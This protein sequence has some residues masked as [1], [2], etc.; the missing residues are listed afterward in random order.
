[1]S[2]LQRIAAM[3]RPTVE[4]YDDPAFGPLSRRSGGDWYGE[5]PFQHPPTGSSS[6]SILI[7]AGEGH[8]SDEQRAFF[9]EILSRYAE[10]W[11]R[12]AEALAAYHPDHTTVES[13]CKYIN[14]PCLCLDPFV[15]DQ[16]RRWSLQYTF[17]D[18]N[19]GDMG[20]F[21][22]FLDWEI[23]CVDAAD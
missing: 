19:E 21:V 6:M 15:D 8:P 7:G 5:V 17:D 23:I 16:P 20:Y 10:L 14:E 2:F 12:V 1:M 3:L 9:G 4:E 13:V 22:E 11:P 18:P